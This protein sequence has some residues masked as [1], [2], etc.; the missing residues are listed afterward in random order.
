[1]QLNRAEGLRPDL[2][3]Q[4]NA[5]D[6]TAGLGTRHHGVC[7]H[8]RQ[9]AGSKVSDGDRTLVRTDQLVVV[10]FHAAGPAGT[11][12]CSNRGDGRRF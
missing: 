5:H 4:Q 9:V 8:H 11:V 7:R 6:F 2:L 1:M 10:R 12:A 3:V